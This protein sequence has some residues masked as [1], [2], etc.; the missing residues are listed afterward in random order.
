MYAVI[1]SG[2]KQHRVE[3]GSKLRVEKLDGKVGYKIVL[4]EVLMVESEG[5]VTI[6]EP[7]IPKAEIK[8]TV[9]DQDRAKK[10]IVFKKKVKK[11]Y[12]RTNGHRQLFTELRIDEI[13]L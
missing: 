8:A 2:G 5:T 1:R 9:L 4:K 13:K 11:Q 12:R 7:L 10:I 3:L 6:G